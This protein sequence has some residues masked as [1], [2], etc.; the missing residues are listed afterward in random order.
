MRETFA[1]PALGACAWMVGLIGGL[2]LFFSLGAQMQCAADPE[3]A[4]Q[5]WR[6]WHGPLTIGVAFGPGI[7]A[8][9]NWYLARRRAT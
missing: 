2:W 6:W 4:W 1:K 3:C 9:V 5:A 7:A 8:T